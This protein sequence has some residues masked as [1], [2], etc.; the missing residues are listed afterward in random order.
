LGG[1]PI[2]RGL[3]KA[4]MTTSL[5]HPE[6]SR[7]HAGPSWSGDVNRQAS[8]YWWSRRPT[9]KPANL[10]CETGKESGIAP[11]PWL[12]AGV[13]SG[14]GPDTPRLPQ[15]IL[16]R[17]TPR[18]PPERVKTT[19]DKPTQTLPLPRPHP[20]PTQSLPRPYPKPTQTLPSPY[21]ILPRRDQTL[22]RHAKT[23]PRP[24]LDPTRPQTEL[25]DHPQTQSEPTQTLPRAYPDPL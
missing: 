10:N 2:L 11:A 25:T 5:G 4:I 18:I 15:G 9:P 12:R 19:K 1:I 21:Q 8:K 22:P 16:P 20:D 23:L 14:E 17:D 3:P 13:F 7:G 24:F 6:A